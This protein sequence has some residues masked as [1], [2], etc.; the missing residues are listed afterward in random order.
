MLLVA[1]IGVVVVLAGVVAEV[2]AVV[3]ARHRA[4]AAADLAAL[5]AYDGGCARAAAVARDNGGRMRGCRP[6]GDSSVVVEVS[7]VPAG[8]AGRAVGA[9][10]V[11][12]RAG[13]VRPPPGSPA[14]GP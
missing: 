7:V 1:M 2:G 8:V 6:Q 14:A 11:F 13:P 10:S 12:A 3:A 4:G 9:V 5:A